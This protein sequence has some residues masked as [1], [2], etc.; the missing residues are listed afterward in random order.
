MEVFRAVTAL[1]ATATDDKQVM[2]QLKGL[3]V[4]ELE[5]FL[6]SIDTIQWH[7]DLSFMAEEHW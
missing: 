6:K 7:P 4:E 5:C 1:A 3:E 2:R